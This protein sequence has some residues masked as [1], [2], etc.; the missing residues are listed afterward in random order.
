MIF[1]NSINGFQFYLVC[2]CMQGFLL[3][4]GREISGSLTQNGSQQAS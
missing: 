3:V 2:L 1:V 4:F